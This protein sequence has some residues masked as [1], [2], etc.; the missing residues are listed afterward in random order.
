MAESAS[1]LAFAQ[2]RATVERLRDALVGMVES[3]R[4]RSQ[5]AAHAVWSLACGRILEQRP[6]GPLVQAT[7][8]FLRD[9]SG[10]STREAYQVRRAMVEAAGA[11]LERS[12]DRSG[13]KL[14]QHLRASW[15]A[16]HAAAEASLVLHRRGLLHE[17][18]LGAE[19]PP[20]VAF[21][22]GLLAPGH[23]TIRC[24]AH[25]DRSPS[26][27]LLLRADGSGGARCLASGCG[28]RL[29]LRR[30]SNGQTVASWA[31][32]SGPV[33]S[34]GGGEASPEAGAGRGG[35]ASEELDGRPAGLALVQRH[36][37]GIQRALWTRD[38]LSALRGAERHALA[39]DEEDVWITVDPQNFEGRDG[40]GRSRWRRGHARWFL[41][42][43]D[44]EAGPE[45]SAWSEALGERLRQLLSGRADLGPGAAPLLDEG[46]PWTGR[47]AILRTSRGGI[48]VVAELRRAWTPEAIAA[49][50]ILRPLVEELALG[51]EEEARAAGFDAR[52]DR[53]CSGLACRRPGWRTLE[54]GSPFRVELAWSQ[55]PAQALG[56]APRPPRRRATLRTRGT[57]A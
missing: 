10:C 35:W 42:D 3:W 31:A 18:L 36:R 51:C 57:T 46:R 48:H 37:S 53:R 17:P 24:P 6:E 39:T 20:D 11:S 49:G 50:G 38:L 13:P 9:G 33:T 47:A 40:R 8:T 45:G 43:L 27:H 34:T 4:G 54:D 44:G 29:S 5:A 55:G 32:S 7:G 14:P 28:A 56:R 2:A 22:L 16:R 23:H 30:G 15:E 12:T 21:E 26:L 19:A 52:W 25:D 1:T 41:I